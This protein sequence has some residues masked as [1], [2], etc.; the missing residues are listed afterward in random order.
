[1]STY[2][3]YDSV[4]QAEVVSGI[5]TDISP[6]DCPFYSGIRTENISARIHEWQEDSLA[7]AADNKAVEGADASMATLSPTTLRTNNTQIFT[8]AFQVSA[9]ADA[10]KT[11]GRAKETAY[12]LAKSLKELKR[13]IERAMVGIDNAAVAGNSSTAREMAS[14]TKQIAAGNT[15]D[16][17]SNATDPLTEAKILETHQAVYTAG[18]DPTQLMIKPADST[19]VA[20]FTAASGRN[21][22]FN[23][24]TTQLTAV[25]DILVNPFGTLNV[26]LNRHQLTTHAFLLDPTMWRTL[27]LRPVTRTLLSKTGDSDKHFVVGEMSLKHMNFSADGMITGL[28]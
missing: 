26:V 21:R 7:A 11:Y 27:V 14:V 2:T 15:V 28:S 5:I 24:Q 23:D 18:G 13:D 22:T 3:T 19:I 6:T 16:A 8:K 10:V 4:G 12:A 9:T 25:V 20:G 17:G 1:M